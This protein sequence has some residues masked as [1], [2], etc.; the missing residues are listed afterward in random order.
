ML[1]LP[2]SVYFAFAIKRTNTSHGGSAHIQ[3]MAK[4]MQQIT[5]LQTN[6]RERA[7]RCCPIFSVTILCGSLH[8]DPRNEFLNIW[9]VDKRRPVGWL[10]T[11]TRR[12]RPGIGTYP[13]DSRKKTTR[14]AR[15]KVVVV[16][17]WQLVSARGVGQSVYSSIVAACHREGVRAKSDKG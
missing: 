7:D 3:G 11:W 16:A 17:V 15:K 5:A 4:P 14:E 2:R 1:P 8:S 10:A 12:L 9:V 6:L 13:M